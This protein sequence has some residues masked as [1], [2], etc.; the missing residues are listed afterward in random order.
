MLQVLLVSC[1]APAA[2]SMTDWIP[3]EAGFREKVVPFMTTHCQRCHGSD[4]AEGELRVDEDL[5]ANVLDPVAKMKWGEVVNVLN[6]HEMPPEG[7]PQ[8]KV[9]E[10]ARVVDWIT[11]EMARAELLRRENVVV[12]RRLNRYEYRNTI[13]DLVGIDFDVDIFPEDPPTGGFDNIGKALTISPMH[14]ELYYDAARKIFDEVFTTGEQPPSLKWRFQP[15]SGN[16]DSNRVTYDK[17]RLIVNAG[18]ND[19]Q[20]DFVVIHHNSWNKNFNV[21]DFKLPYQGPYVVRIRAASKVPSRQEVVDSARVYLEE[22]IAKAAEKNPKDA[23]NR[24]RSLEEDLKHFKTDRMYDYGPARIKLIQNLGGQ[25]RVVAEFDVDASVDNP[26]VYDIPLEFSTLSAG[27]TIEYGYNIP[28]VLENFWMQTGDKFARPELWIDWMELEGPV[29][30]QWPLPAKAKLVDPG[31]YAGRD[32]GKQ[33]EAIISEFMRKAYRRPVTKDEVEENLV[34]YRQARREAPSPADALKLSLTAVLMSPHFLYLT[35]PYDRSSLD[36]SQKHLLTPH[37]LA[38]RLSYFL[39]C[40][41]PDDELMALADSGEL[42]QPDVLKGQVRRMLKDDKSRAFVKTF[43]G[44]W[45][46][47]REVGANPPAKD[48]YPR[49][50]RHLEISIV[51]E[52]E[53]FFAENLDHELS[54]M[55]FVQSDFVVINERLARFY[56]IS[57]VK[58]DEFRKV[59]VPRGVHRGGIIT[60]ASMLSITSNGT[61]TSPVKRGTWVM[62]NLLGIDPGLPVANAGEIA[63]KV[64]GIDKATVRQRLEIHRSLP[65]CARCHNK[66]DPLG[67]ALENFN[68]A[69]EWREQEGFGYK[70][71]IGRD[72]PVIDASSQL[73]DGTPVKG[74]RGLQ[75]ALIDREELFL[76]CL[77]R[78]LMTYGLGR[79]LALADEGTVKAAVQHMQRPKQDTLPSLI[80]FVVLSE[81]FGSK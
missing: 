62:K 2:D 8:P 25:P 11:S 13:R 34:L 38:S 61:R 78:K 19:V 68:A 57:G 60:Q 28:S 18:Q 10:V 24:R 51:K 66:I 76:A 46:G 56:D 21:R 45:L 17:Q 43:A 5:I 47:L 69:G 79:E 73:L 40:T 14:I 72:D 63:P 4:V 9:D 41:M 20:G 12:M 22:R 29:Y 30:E 52:A 1:V 81:A 48:L 71:R 6:S 44:Q 26:K 49:Y 80:E 64:P 3:D 15:E 23:E 70:G 58:G 50:D 74:V 35:E 77:T 7:E 59:D 54:V 67:L 36:P 55:N 53:E 32:E 65:Q 37:Q 75:K 27:L 42:T 31:R 33:A 16:S 39:W